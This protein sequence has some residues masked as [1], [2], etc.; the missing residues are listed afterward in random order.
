M[1]D[2]VSLLDSGF[3]RDR[4]ANQPQDVRYGK[5]RHPVLFVGG[6]FSKTGLTA[7]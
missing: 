3:V 1:A 2:R 4:C 5:G 7:A 6:D